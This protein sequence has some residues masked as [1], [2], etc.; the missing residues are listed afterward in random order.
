M[1]I[2]VALHHATHYRY[3]RLVNLG[4]QTV[5]LRPA[6]HC[7]TPVL[8]Y[9]LTVDPPKHF[10]NWLQDPHGNYLARHV[11]TQPA[12]AMSV[13][14]DLTVE[15]SVINPFDFF[16]EEYAEAFPFT[17]EEHLDLDLKPFRVL[18]ESG[19]LLRDYLRGIDQTPRRTIDFL[20]Q[21]NQQLQQDIKYLIRMEPGVQSCEET[22]ARGSGSCRDSAWLLMQILRH[23]GFATRFVSGYLIQLAPDVKSL[24]GPSG[25]AVD[26]TDLHA[27]AEVFLPG[28]GWIG[29]DPT[30]GLLVSE[31]HIPLACTPLPTTAA[32]IEGSVDDSEVEFSF[33]MF[34]ERIHEDPRVT[35]PY[36]EQ[37][38]QRVLEVGQ[39][40]DDRLK[41]DDV[42]LTMGG[43]PTFV[44]IDDMEGEE[45]T[46]GAVGLHKYRLS[47][48]LM[49]RLQQRFAPG[50]LLH[51][52][53][54]KWYPGE[55]LPRWAMTCLWR[56]DGEPIWSK[57]ELFATSQN[58]V[59]AD[60]TQAAE[61]VSR[62]SE[63]IAVDP[64]WVRPAYEDVWNVIREEHKLPVNVDPRKFDLNRA[65]ERARL[66][67]LLERGATSPVGFVLPLKRPWWQASAKWESGPWPFRGPKLFLIPGDSPIG[68]RLPLES[69]PVKPGDSHDPRP[70]IYELDPFDS[71][72]PLP[73][74]V[75]LR[76]AVQQTSLQMREIHPQLQR[77]PGQSSSEETLQAL[78]NQETEQA[79]LPAGG[80][81]VRTALCV[82]PRDGR[83]CVFMP[84]VGTLE[85]YLEL[86]AAIEATADS[87]SVPV[88][89][90]GYLPPFDP[91]L[92]AIK[93][94]PDPGVIE[95]NIQPS[96]TW[97]ELVDITETLYEEARLCRL[98][99]E[100]FQLDGRH[101]GT[102]GGNHVVMGGITPQDSPFLRRPD[103]LAS[104]ITYW[105][106]HPSLS[107]L[108]SG[109]FI[110]P[111]SQAPRVDEGRR[112]AIYELQIALD[113]LSATNFRPP[114][115]VDRL[116]RHL[117][118]DLTGNTHRAEFCID[119]LYSPDSATGRL[120]LVELRAFEMPPHARMSLTQQLLLRSIVSWFW[121]EP[122]RRKLVDW[123][124]R[125]HD[126]F[127]L[128]YYLMTDFRTVIRDM[129][130]AGIPLE[131]AWFAPHIEFRCP[132]VGTVCYDGMQLEIRQAIEPW[133]VLGEQGGTS[134]T[135]RYV[136]SSV[137]RL[138]VKLTGALSER[139][140]VTC[141]GRKIP[142]QPTATQG[143]YVGGVRYRAWQP[144]NC[145]HPTI[146]VHV[147]LIFDIV[148]RWSMRS[149]GGCR[150][151]IDNAGGLNPTSFPVNA[152][153]AES[154][155]SNRFFRFGHTPGSVNVVDEWPDIHYPMTLDLRR[156][157]HA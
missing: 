78:V 21:V 98:G 18:R 125:I 8:S 34:I 142:L 129:N 35:K 152:L 25:T 87:L 130:E 137:E 72:V 134:G 13:V 36:A 61:F 83:L 41:Q 132:L 79:S 155:R 43:E 88:S 118:V 66:A 123:G 82:E 147:P 113:Q 39:L 40:V 73:R 127:M 20:V 3:D 47:E 77:R 26:F 16:I 101:T 103:L 49:Q 102:G 42:R 31:G 94:T 112:D 6:P 10:V 44:S 148:D 71:R 86:T 38:W 133:Y 154:R 128:P 57:P 81:L 90:E 48:E 63:H 27:W 29:L 37:E 110:G 157:L 135:T 68:L 100:K 76:N 64:R 65:E 5:R 126:Q 105:N 17:Y 119:K 131:Y 7:R 146:P 120:G 91:R 59:Q 136:D 151:H 149:I 153:E 115:L 95:V 104:L 122:Y 84:P 140:L 45:W 19:P 58:S 51:F 50:A 85:D 141:N 4:P 24:D 70:D 139:Y 14:V 117:L 99:T 97:E 12:R 109:M 30:S 23:C 52:G 92:E 121:R 116:F 53:Q 62:L 60:I 74:Y 124:T 114:W 9:S 15:M 96:Q 56:K 143:E 138:E 106:N 93:V 2:R 107:Y 33:E 54:G 150:Y 145:L 108:F 1:S 75:E 89:L 55:S 80:Q 28:A 144:P 67:R 111:T 46:V 22:L 32:P 156:S 69:L 11:F